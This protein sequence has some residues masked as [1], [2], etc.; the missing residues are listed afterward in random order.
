MFRTCLVVFIFAGSAAAA[1]R[2]LADDVT[3]YRCTDASGKLTLRD[4]PCAKGQQQQTRTMLRPKD[5]PPAARPPVTDALPAPPLPQRIL[6][7]NA[8]R[9]LYE[10]VRPDG[11]HY[12]SD[13]GEGAPRFVPLWTLDIPVVPRSLALGD[14]IGAPTPRP[15]RDRPGPPRSLRSPQ[16]PG[17]GF[18][19]PAAGTWVRDECHPLPQV[20]VCA[21][22][23]DRRDEIRRRFFNAMPNE[24]AEL[25]T[26]ERGVN[27]R[28]SDDCGES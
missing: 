3:I 18:V 9:P 23:R 11:E 22:L 24:R 12:T 21:R 16:F 25:N 6:V 20:E 8:P 2:A 4:T 15:P 14:R 5:A 10:C 26:E 27:A 13:T 7:R 28:L 17:N 19:F 1:P